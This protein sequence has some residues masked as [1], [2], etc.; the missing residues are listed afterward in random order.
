MI[1]PYENWTTRQAVAALSIGTVCIALWTFS[2]TGFLPKWVG[3]VC[4]DA[5][6]IA[7]GLRFI[8]LL[9]PKLRTPEK[10]DLFTALVY[11][12]SFVAAFLLGDFGRNGSET[13][14][15]AFSSN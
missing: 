11:V 3:Y 10:R 4:Y 2:G 15:N 7:W 12:P 8:Q 5:F 6:L 14:W 1:R 13:P 9:W